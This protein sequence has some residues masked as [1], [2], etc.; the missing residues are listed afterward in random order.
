MRRPQSANSTA[1]NSTAVHSLSTKLVPAK[2]VLQAVAAADS[3]AH[4]VISAAVAVAAVAEVVMTAA[5]VAVVA[6]AAEVA[7]NT[8]AGNSS[9]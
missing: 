4:V 3:T 9:L 8:V 2:T 5:A 6:A 7:V 1:K